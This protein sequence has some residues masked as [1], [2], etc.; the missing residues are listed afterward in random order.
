MKTLAHSLIPILVL[1]VTGSA[2]AGPPAVEPAATL[3]WLEAMMGQF[4]IAVLVAFL[5]GIRVSQGPVNRSN[6]A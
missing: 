5:V 3:S 1:T 4:Y 2:W 6:S